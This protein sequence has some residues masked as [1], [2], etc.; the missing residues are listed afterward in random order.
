MEATALALA[1][2]P[3]EIPGV[4]YAKLRGKRVPGSRR[5][6]ASTDEIVELAKRRASLVS[7]ERVR[8]TSFG[9]A[10][11]RDGQGRFEDNLVFQQEVYVLVVG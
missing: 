10:C 4:T 2:V 9:S 8:A 6:L 5:R 3:D 11:L 1:R 7:K